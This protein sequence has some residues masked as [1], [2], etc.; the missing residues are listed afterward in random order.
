MSA[1]EIE[2]QGLGKQYRIGAAKQND[3]SVTL[4]DMLVERVVGAFRRSRTPRGKDSGTRFWALKDI[5]L[6]ITQGE[7]VGI[8]GRN[9]SGKS[10]LLKIL[11]D[12]LEP[13]V[14]RAEIRGR[15]ASLL[16][17]GTGFH[18]ELTGR[19]NIYLNG[20]LLGMRQQEVRDNFDQIVEFA[21]IGQFLDTPVKRYSS[22]MYVRLAFAVAAHLEPEVLI[23]DEVLAVG[24]F[25]F[26]QRCLGRM[27]EVARGGRTVLFVSHNIAAVESLCSRCVLLDGG[28]VVEDGEPYTVTREYRRRMSGSDSDAVVSLEEKEGAGR[29]LRVLKRAYLVDEEGSLTTSIPVSRAFELRIGVNM[30]A[31][32]KN[33]VF[34]VRVES[35]YGVR[36]LT[37]QSPIKDGRFLEPEGEQEI[38]CHIAEFPLTPGIYNLTLA[39]FAR[40]ELIDTVRD[41]LAVTVTDGE[42]F[43]EGR[44]ANSGVCVARSEWGA[45]PPALAAAVTRPAL[46][47]KTASIAAGKDYAG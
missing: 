20:A 10:T 23:V 46:L 5:D 15:V 7:V 41:A 3:H 1:T 14:G 36:M 26:Q 12:I 31:G 33:V 25:E 43:S 22:G 27:K 34:V 2:I 29:K 4:R 16:E 44:G 13:T 47:P 11:S 8:I 39:V 35:M 40:E 21:G 45:G 24:D 19:E 42:V 28:R 30:P 9:G 38:R 18:A 37:L 17:V 6:S 32:L